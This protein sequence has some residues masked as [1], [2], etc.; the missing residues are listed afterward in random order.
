M[1]SGPLLD[2]LIDTSYKQQMNSLLL[3]SKIFSNTLFG[4]GATVGKVPL[5][6]V[7]GAGPNNATVL[8]AICNCTAQMECGGKK[9]AEYIAKLILPEI[10]KMED[11]AREHNKKHPGVVDLVYFDGASNVKKAGDIMKVDYRCMTVCHGSEHVVALF[12]S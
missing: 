9:D 6:N 7:L 1:V 12:F 11:K 2:V 4:N 8:L 5:I 3:E 10:Q